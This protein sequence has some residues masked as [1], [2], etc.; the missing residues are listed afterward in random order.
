MKWAAFKGGKPANH[1][2]THA[3]CSEQLICP[4]NNDSSKSKQVQKKG[5]IV[6]QDWNV[7]WKTLENSI[8][9]LNN[10]PVCNSETR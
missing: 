8:K 10:K 4:H 6:C 3:T 7:C 9:S 2:L 1:T 5:K